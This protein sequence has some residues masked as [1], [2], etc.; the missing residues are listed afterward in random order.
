MGGI[1]D[2]KKFTH[3]LDSRHTLMFAHIYDMALRAEK[4]SRAV[5]GD[6]LSENST[7]LVL[8]RAHLLPSAPLFFGGYDGAQRQMIAFLPEYEEA[9]FPVSAIRIDTPNIK[10][11]SHRDFLGSVLGLGIK[12]EKCGDIIINEDC[13]FIFLDSD[14]ASFVSNELTK[15]GREGVKTTLIPLSEVTVRE[16]EFKSITGT[17]SSLR[18]DSVVSLFTGKGRSKAAEAVLSGLVFVNGICIQ[19]SDAHLRDGDVISVRGKGKA[20]LKEG[21][22]S[23]KDRI[24]ITL[25]AWV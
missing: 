17:V 19:K 18:L 13:A 2:K 11:L 4:Y 20:T 25:D 6:F 15:V 23:K 8:T 12:R 10:R 3:S 7:A 22:K 5:Y 14:V 16:K 1:T 24:F 9:Y 21:G